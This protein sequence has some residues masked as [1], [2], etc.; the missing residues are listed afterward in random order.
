MITK[1]KFSIILTRALL[2]TGIPGTIGPLLACSVTNLHPTPCNPVDCSMPVFPALYYLPEFAQIHVHWVGDAIQPPHPLPPPSSPAFILSQHHGH[3]QSVYSLHQG[4]K[5]SEL[6][7][8]YQLFQWIFR[9]DFLQDWF[10]LLAVQG[11]L[12]SL[13]QSHNSKASVLQHSAFFRVQ[14]SHPYMI[15]G[16]NHSSDYTDLCWQSDVFAF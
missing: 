9:V 11:T 14:L 7:L 5:V 4:A 6:Q 15:I 3:F 8:Q 1:S 13:L 2:R 16:K 10:D 12:K